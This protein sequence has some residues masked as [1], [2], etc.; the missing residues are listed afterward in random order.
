MARMLPA[1]VFSGTRSP[2][3]IEIFEKLKLDPATKDWT[4]LHSLDI[5]DHI[6]QIQGEIDF[7]VIA[8]ERGVLCLE[9]KAANEITREQGVWYFGAN[10][11]RDVRGPFKQVSDAM[12]SLR[13]TLVKRRPDL[14]DIP[15]CSGV[16]FPYVEFDVQ[17][18]E[19]HPFQLIDAIK[20]KSAPIGSLIE[21]MLDQFIAYFASHPNLKW[22]HPKDG[23]PTKEQVESISQALRPEFEFFESPAS[24]STRIAEELKHYTAEQFRALDA[25]E[26]NPRV[27]FT[28]P[29]G[30]GKTLLAIEA[31]RRSAAN[32]RRALLVCF[33]RLLGH[34]LDEQ[35]RSLGQNLACG[36][37]H[38]ELLATA[39]INVPS[40]QP[41]GFWSVTLPAAALSS[42][43]DNPISRKFDDLIV[44]EAQ[45]IFF[46]NAYVA[47]LDR[48]L[49]GGFAEGRWRVFGDF[50]RQTIYAG[51]FAATN[52]PE[53]IRETG[54]PEYSLRINCRNPPRIAELVHVLGG[55]SPRYS[56]VLRPDNGAEPQILVYRS[57]DHQAKLLLAAIRQ[58]LRSGYLPRDIVVLS[59]RR[60]DESVV[61]DLLQD[62]ELE[63]GGFGVKQGSTT[64]RYGTIHEFKGL[65]SPIVVV[66]DVIGVGSPLAAS[67]F[68]TSI[69]RALDQLTILISD[70][71]R[72]RFLEIINEQTS[73][74][75]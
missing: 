54:A 21:Q 8:P 74:S 64:I 56:E 51:T 7:C 11:T 47:Y 22:F 26:K 43:S 23:V 29:A 62:E 67:L 68:Y 38:S 46:N 24:R 61:A 55:L 33:N 42:L 37:L 9:V 19:W 50:E 58:F 10:R 71:A 27:I 69:T 30:T 75:Q 15:F 36:T 59:T 31:A 28:G 52:V 72:E 53:C 60:S 57:P 34:W 14:S 20:Y 5:A 41:E 65:E 6:T 2:G 25:M 18:P 70:D 45:D 16:V 48:I 32:G 17:S 66:T 39:R 63:F 49:E 44:D 12:H 13:R 40:P 35:M 4:V 73:E 1:S 3:E